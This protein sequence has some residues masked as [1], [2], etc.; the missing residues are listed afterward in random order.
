MSPRRRRR[1]CPPFSGG[2]R[3]RLPVDHHQRATGQSVIIQASTNLLSLVPVYTN[4]EPFTFTNFDSTNFPLRFYRAVPAVTGFR[5]E[6]LRFDRRRGDGQIH[7][8]RFFFAARRAR[9]WTPTKWPANSSSP[10]SPRWR[11]FKTN[12]AENCLL[13]TALETRRTGANRF[14]RR[15][16]AEKTGGHPAPAHPRTLAGAGR[17]VAT[18]KLSAG[19]RR[20]PAAV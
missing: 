11:K 16:R 10:A 9:S 8:R 3:R 12:S 19:R 20:H 15:G 6:T 1:N 5:H 17:N 14:R 4:T 18:G 2:Q 7:R 13:P